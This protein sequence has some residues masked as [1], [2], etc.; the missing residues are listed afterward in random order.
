MRLRTGALTDEPRPFVIAASRLRGRHRRVVDALGDRRIGDHLG[1]LV[2]LAPPGVD[3][4]VAERDLEGR[5]RVASGGRGRAGHQPLASAPGGLAQELLDETPLALVAHRLAD[6]PAGRREGQVGHLGAQVGQRPLLLRLDVG[7]R[8]DAQPLELF[9][10]RRDVRVAGLLG[11]LLGAVDDLLRLA[12]GLGDRLGPFGGRRL[13]LE[14]RRFGVRQTLLDPGPS[15]GQHLGDGL[16]EERLEQREE[17]D[18]VRRRDDDPEQVDGQA[19]GRRF[20]GR[21]SDRLTGRG[22]DDP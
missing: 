13:A 17:Q 5:L 18:E 8:P 3:R 19:A 21:Q 10:G 20:L 1:R 9:A 6:D 7:G 11:H 14:A 2:E 4:A 15:V 22:A 16:G 12:P